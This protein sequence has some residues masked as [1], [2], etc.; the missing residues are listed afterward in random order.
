MCESLRVISRRTDRSSS[1]ITTG[2]RREGGVDRFPFP[3]II[4]VQSDATDRLSS[5]FL[6]SRYLLSHYTFFP[7]RVLLL[8]SL[9]NAASRRLS[10]SA[11]L[12]LAVATLG[13]AL[14]LARA[15]FD[16]ACAQFSAP[17]YSLLI[18]FLRFLGTH[19]TVPPCKPLQAT[20]APFHSETT[21][22]R[23]LFLLDSNLKTRTNF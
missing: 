20:F 8:S 21:V 3:T 7:R 14:L 12:P 10:V 18:N 1:T 19:S 23:W 5:P 11:T 15:E 9:L 16:A 2:K 13:T 22:P 6:L 4:T 17:F